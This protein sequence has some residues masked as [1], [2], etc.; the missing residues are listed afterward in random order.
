[1]RSIRSVKAT[2]FATLIAIT[3]LA[4]PAVVGPAVAADPVI[5]TAGTTQDFDSSNPY[6]SA[7]VSSY[8]AFQLTY[9]LLVDFGLDTKPVPGFADKWTRNADNVT[10]HIR[11]GM[12]WSDGQP[13]TAAD[14][15]FSWQLAI[16]AHAADASVGLGYIDQNLKDAG[17]TKV[18]CPDAETLIASTTD[19]SDRIYQIYLP[20]IPK[21]IWG[22]FTYKTIADQ[23]F[24]A[25]LVGTGPYTLAEWKT[26]QYMRFVRNP[27]YWGTQGIADEVVLRIFSSSD[28]M[29]QALKAGDIQYAHDINADQLKALKGAA[30]ISTVIGA[31]NG[32]SQLAFNV[33]GTG[34]G[35]TIDGGGPSTKALLDPK[36]RDALGYAI[37]KPLLIDRVLG[38]YGDVGTTIVP[39]VLGDLHVEPAQPRS[40][41]IDLAK[42]KL[43]D[44]GYV[45]DAN[46]KR[47]DK[48]GK[49]IVLRLV[50]PDSSDLYSKAAEF[51]KDWYGQLGVEV[52]PGIYDSD[53]LVDL[54]L[55]PEAGGKANKA[56][57]DIEFWGWS[58]N[59]DPNALLAVFRCDEIGNLSDSNFCDPAYDSLYDQESKLSGPERN[60]VLSTMQNM[61]YDLAVY[62]ILYYDA[63]L[64]AYR[65]NKFTG[66][67]NMPANGTP[68]FTYGT[69]NYTQL[70]DAT[71]VPTPGPTSAATTAPGTSSAPATPSPTATPGGTSSGG[72]NTTLIIIVLVLV[73]LAVVLGWWYRGRRKSAAADE[74]G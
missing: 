47:L 50:M 40:F 63:N 56:K 1:M 73:V 67:Q 2:R 10:F 45:L 52:Q 12:K 22:T 35:K 34:T 13:A 6:Q 61:I 57:Y 51:I 44:A 15:C 53:T 7:L 55:P 16:D 43:T 31:A 23:S 19:Q 36:F 24:D 68:L 4:L 20:I 3:A 42:Q 18:E 29:V 60:A 66:L 26:G 62:D 54:L 41:N 70:T 28:T 38:G 48:E 74:E 58:G 39:P 11:T 49:P 32:W 9:N 64:D 33:Y 17:V 5:F 8:E 72:D 30:N 27:N 69:F 59:P 25:P 37:D 65:T 71:A 14:A 21:H 46:G